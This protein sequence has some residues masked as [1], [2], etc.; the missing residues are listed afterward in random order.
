ME[1]IVEEIKKTKLFPVIISIKN[2]KRYL[3]MV[4]IDVNSQ[5]IP[6]IHLEYG[7]EKGKKTVKNEPILKGKNIGKKNETTPYDQAFNNAL[8][9]WKKQY[10]GSISAAKIKGEPIVYPMRSLDYNKSK[11]EI[12]YPW[13]WQV[14]LDGVR[15]LCYYNVK[16]KRVILRSKD[17]DKEITNLSHISEDMVKLFGVVGNMPDLYIDFEFFGIYPMKEKK[18]G[19]R[20]MPIPTQ[21]INSILSASLYKS[22][23]EEQVFKEDIKA[24]V[25]D[26]F[27]VTQPYSGMT[28]DQRYNYLKMI[29]EKAAKNKIVFKHLVLVPTNIV[30]AESE[31]KKLAEAS[32][33]VGY[34][35]IMLRNPAGLYK[36]ASSKTTGGSS[37]LLKYKIKQEGDAIILG[38]EL[39][40]STKKTEFNFVFKVQ[41]AFNSNLTYEITANG[42]AEMK[43]KAFENIKYYKNKIILFNYYGTT[44]VGKPKHAT[45]ILETNPK[46]GKQNY[47]IK[48]QEKSMLGEKNLIEIPVPKKPEV[49]Q[50]IKP[51][52][53]VEEK[54]KNDK[55]QEEEEEENNSSDEENN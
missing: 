28:F 8:S 24:Y 38:A 40:K 41:D 19:N 2:K 46:T 43:K 45:P 51:D 16:L 33:A 7:F 22:V 17:A 50:E 30:N 39:K 29:F 3:W 25:F 4:R 27:F 21:I 34:E 44:L 31:L 53:K 14:K 23:Y 9:K 10:K 13:K 42:D 15:G 37:D 6:I 1:T 18:T 52:V 47:K 12:I 49:K 36:I 11:R 5:N 35:G 54:E 32:I 26:C 20:I 48:F 55:K